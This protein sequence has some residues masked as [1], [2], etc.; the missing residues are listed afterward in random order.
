MTFLQWMLVGL[1]FVFLE[2]FV[3]GVYLV[4]FGLS[5]FVMGGSTLFIEMPLTDQLV[6]FAFV[7]AIFAVIGW[8]VYG[9]VI[10][11]TK[12]PVGYEH[13]NDSAAMHVGRVYPLT[14]DVVDGRAKVKVGDSVWL[15][16]CDAPL[17]AGTA[18][19]V[20]GVENGVILKVK[21]QV[22]KNS[23]A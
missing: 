21:K 22:D 4:W 5:A 3:P 2:L 14:E 19:V 7:S 18:V 12:V 23:K 15:A 13:L 11:D 17:K 1:I 6:W 16:A 8:R 9:R 10:K 20:M